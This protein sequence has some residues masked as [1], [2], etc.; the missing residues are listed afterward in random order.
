MPLLGHTG[1]FH[2]AWGDFHSFKNQEALEYECFRMIAHG[3][4]AMIG[5]QLPPEGKIEEHVYHLIG[6]VYRQIEAKEAWCVGAKAIVDIGV[7]TPEEF[8]TVNNRGG[9]PSICG[10]HS[11]LQEVAHQFDL[12]DSQTNFDHYKVI[13]LPDDIP[14]DADLK[15]KLDAYIA[16]GGAVIASFESGMNKDKTEFVLDALAVTM[17]DEGP[18]D[19]YGELVRGRHY[20]RGD[21]AEYIVPEGIVG[22]GLPPT[23]HVMYIRGMAVKANDNA[24]ILAHIT[25]SHFDRTYQHFCSHRQTPSSGQ[26][27]GPAIVQNGRVV[28]FSNP[29]FSQ[30]YHNAPRWCRTMFLNVL[31]TLLPNPVVQHSGPSTLEITINHQENENRDILHLLHYIPIRR[32]EIDIIEDVIPVYNIPISLRAGQPIQAIQLAP[33]G[34]T[35]NFEVIDNRVTFTVPVVHGH[36]MIEIIY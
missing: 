20:E 27:A 2:T 24:T 14:V 35:I 8:G 12:I 33:S 7:L 18:R 19:R 11:M 23:E 31:N 22:N 29:I 4:S 25:P 34:E 30:Y 16:N 9:Q 6:N 28:Y 21:Y 5:D 15:H 13:I 32:S 17:I 36:Q 3:V 10:V 1:K 26:T